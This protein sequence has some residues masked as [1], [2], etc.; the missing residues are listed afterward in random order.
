[1]C[2]LR[3]KFAVIISVF[4]FEK[5]WIK[6]DFF[7]FFFHNSAPTPEPTP[8]P[9]PAP[10]PPP[11]PEPT[12]KPVNIKQH[13]HSH[14]T[15]RLIHRIFFRH[16]NRHQRLRPRQRPCQHRMNRLPVLH[17][18]PRVNSALTT[19]YMRQDAVGGA[20][21]CVRMKVT[22]VLMRLMLINKQCVRH[23]TIFI[24]VF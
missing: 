21:W 10:T 24:L 6:I 18:T 5:K 3:R 22:R 23:R 9:T 20:A 1:M 19:S 4:L 11:T 15:L 16:Q 8:N 7:Q 17:S 14:T 2:V 13:F 12:P